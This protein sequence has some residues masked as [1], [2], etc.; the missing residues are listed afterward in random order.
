MVLFTLKVLSRKFATL[1]QLTLSLPIETECRYVVLM[2]SDVFVERSN[3]IA[4]TLVA[5]PELLGNLDKPG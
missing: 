2:V 5:M 3:A 1:L 4:I